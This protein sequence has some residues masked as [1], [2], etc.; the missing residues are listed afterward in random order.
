MP[1]YETSVITMYKPYA[2]FDTNGVMV[3]GA[4]TLFEGTWSK[5]KIAELLPVDYNPEQGK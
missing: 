4:S 5:N 3:S 1:N 2:L